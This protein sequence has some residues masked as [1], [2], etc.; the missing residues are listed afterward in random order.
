[1]ALYE[2]EMFDELAYD[3]AEGA[4]DAF[5]EYDEYDEY[6][7]FDELDEFGESDEFDEYDEFDETNE[8]DDSDE[9]EEYDE[10]DEFD[11]F[12]DFEEDEFDTAMAYALSAEDEDEFFK[13]LFRGIKKVAK[14]VRR[15]V[16]K[17]AP[18][19]GRIARIAGPILSK[20]PHP[21]AQIGAKAARLLGRL[22]AEGAS[23]EDALEAFAEMAVHDRRVL[24][25]VA[26][27][28]ARTIL[29]SR[30]KRMSLAQRKRAVKDI[31][32][33]AK[34]LVARRGPK[35]IRA[36]PKIVRS[37]KRT[38]AVKSTPPTMRAKVVKNAAK[39]VAAS[40]NLTR[41]LAKPKAKA[42]AMVRKANVTGGG[43]SYVIPGPTRITIS[44]A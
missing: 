35:A 41:K 16:R 27:I 23:E 13:K 28:G 7:E 33:A 43:K 17:A 36:L 6:E 39:K 42:I 30:G 12:D 37:V 20:I 29:K 2:E 9:F 21:Y 14:K 3:E 26:G 8:F 44:A 18:V 40:A 19:V 31:K 24:P 25:I 22:R 34:I 32:L 1:M 5:D 10:S 11:E 15:V 38:A 4:A